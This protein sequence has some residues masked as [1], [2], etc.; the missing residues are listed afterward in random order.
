MMAKSGPNE[1]PRIP[2]AEFTGRMENVKKKMAEQGID[3]LVAYANQ[4]DPGHVRYLADT[5]GIN[6]SAAVVVPL[7]GEPILCSGQA[8]QAWSAHTSRIKEVRILP[9][10]GEVAGTE[11]LVGDQGT[12]ADLFNEIKGKHKIT[13]VGTVGTLIFPQIIY[14]QIQKS[15]P[16]AEMV[17]AEALM[18]ELRFSKSKN[19]I[20][21]MRKGAEILDGAFGDAVAK[22]RPGWTELDIHAEIVSG[23]LKRGAEGTAASWEPMIPSGPERANLCMNKNSLREVQ[24]GEIICLQAGAV[25]EGLNAALCTPLVLGEI[26]AEIKKAVNCTYEARNAIISTLKAGVTS[27][28][29][30]AAGKKVL[31]SGGYAEH[32]PYAMLHNI[33]Y[34]ECESPWMA[35]DK[36]FVIVEGAVVCLDGFLFRLPWGSFRIEDT[37]VVTADGADVLTTF[38][39]NFIPKHFG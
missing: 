33:G 30:N 21:C 39:E 5:E 15:F 38:N 11:Y 36:D 28:E 25:Y 1:A 17:N 27:R 23:M 37:I 31:A 4:L 20:A 13:K 22:I 10:V 34:L 16:E 2:D 24:E 14:G 32:S 29:V 19:E 12:F 26:P 6:E 8:C 3:L 7:K 35:E 18:F 9:E